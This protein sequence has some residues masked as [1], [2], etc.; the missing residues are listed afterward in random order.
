M[1]CCPYVTVLFPATVSSNVWPTYLTTEFPCESQLMH[2]TCWPGFTV[3]FHNT[4]ATDETLM[5]DVLSAASQ[6]VACT[7]CRWS[8]DTGFIFLETCCLNQAVLRESIVTWKCVRQQEMTHSPAGSPTQ[9]S[10]K[11][12][13][14]APKAKQT[15]LEP[16]SQPKNPLCSVLISCRQSP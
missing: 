3:C 2:M 5:E 14:T 15:F 12:M 16:Q 1:T 13:R 11:N 8:E 10:L 4:L 9:P 6:P 7:L